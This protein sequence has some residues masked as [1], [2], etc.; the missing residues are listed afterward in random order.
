MGGRAVERGDPVVGSTV[1][2][3]SFVFRDDDLEKWGEAFERI[4][5]K[6]TRRPSRRLT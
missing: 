3:T 6:L 4:L 2:G 5:Q 1:F